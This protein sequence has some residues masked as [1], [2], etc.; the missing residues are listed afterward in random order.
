MVR[1][2][3]SALLEKSK[4]PYPLPFEF[5]LCW[6]VLWGAIYSGIISLDV[7]ISK[8]GKETES[9]QKAI[10]QFLCWGLVVGMLVGFLG[11][12]T[13]ALF[14]SQAEV[15]IVLG[16]HLLIFSGAGLVVAL[17][18]ILFVSGIALLLRIG[19]LFVKINKKVFLGE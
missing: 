12:S 8:A 18:T 4:S 11:G 16:T 17:G 14:D 19:S 7:V 10:A 15:V 2:I 1:E 9:I 5:S 13:T 3:R 6:T